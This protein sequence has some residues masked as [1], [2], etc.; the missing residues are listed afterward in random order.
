MAPICNI[1]DAR[2][3]SLPVAG[4]LNVDNIKPQALTAF[5]TQWKVTPVIPAKTPL[6]QITLDEVNPL[7]TVL[8]TF[9]SDGFINEHGIWSSKSG[10]AFFRARLELPEAMK[11][12]FLMGLRRS[13][14]A[15]A[16]QRLVLHRHGRHESLPGRP[17]QAGD[18]A[19]RRPA[20][21][22][23]RHDLNEGLAWGFMLRFARLDV[24]AK[25]LRSGFFVR[26]AFAV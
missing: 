11:L 15:V 21:G 3:L 19:C 8:K 18:A 4:P 22:R 9:G 23:H 16:R 13:L 26:P 17:K 10:F 24:S 6:D 12:E 2:D 5:V 7:P 1:T 25:E 14:P 20:R